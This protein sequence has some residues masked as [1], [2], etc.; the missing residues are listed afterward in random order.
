MRRQIKTDSH[1]EIAW[2]SGVLRL[3][4]TPRNGRQRLDDSLAPLLWACS[5]YGDS[6]DDTFEVRH[7]G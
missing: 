6:R 4:T 7:G 5:R 2:E 3:E 1:E